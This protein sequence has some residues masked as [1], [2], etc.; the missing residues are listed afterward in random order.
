MKRIGE[1]EIFK[2]K[3]FRIK[4]I[5]IQTRDDKHVTYQILEKRDAALIVPITEQGNILL[6]NEYFAAIDEYQLSLP[7]GRIEEGS[8]ELETANKELQEEVGYRAKKIE[9]LGAVTMSP[10]YLK[11]RTHIFLARDLVE[12]KLPGDEDEELEVS[13]YPFSQ[14]EDLIEKGKITEARVITALFLARSYLK[15]V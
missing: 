12:S 8:N 13:E 2:T 1:K 3:L 4:D 9:F 7:K 15:K 6:I 10:G 11:Q 5:D 14:F